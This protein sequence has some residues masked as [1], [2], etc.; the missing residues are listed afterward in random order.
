MGSIIMSPSTNRNNIKIGQDVLIVLKEDQKTPNLYYGKV[1]E[2]LTNKSEHTR[3]IKVR[4]E[5]DH[6]GRVQYILMDK[7][8]KLWFDES[9]TNI[10]KTDLNNNYQILMTVP[11]DNNYKSER[12]FSSNLGHFLKLEASIVYTKTDEH[13]YPKL[14]PKKDLNLTHQNKYKVLYFSSIGVI[15]NGRI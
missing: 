15:K 3:G 6:V 2:I 9:L 11:F 5:D 10:Y 13:P 12:I 14:I 7:L 1:K 4:L 8:I